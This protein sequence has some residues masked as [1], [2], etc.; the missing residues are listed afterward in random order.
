MGPRVSRTPQH[1][2]QILAGAS[3]NPKLQDGGRL[4]AKCSS[5]GDEIHHSAD[6]ENL[7]PI[8]FVHRIHSF[9]IF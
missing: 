5:N 1:R 9:R 3:S 2:L 6:G 7:V 4:M 8:L